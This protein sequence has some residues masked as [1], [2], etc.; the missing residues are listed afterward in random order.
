MAITTHWVQDF[1][2]FSDKVSP[3]ASPVLTNDL[4]N[5]NVSHGQVRPRAGLSN[6]HSDSTPAATTIIGLFDY[7]LVSGTNQIVRMLEAG[8]E[9]WNGSSWLDITP[10][11]TLTGSST[12]RPQACVIDD[13][14]IFT[15]EGADLPHKY[16][17]SG[18]AAIIA[19]GL[20][21]YGKVIQAYLGFLMLGDVS[22]SGA[23]T[24]ITDGQRIINY[25]DDWDTDWSACN[26]NEIVLWETPGSL[27]RMLVL[28]RDL[29]CYKTDG[30]VRVT[31][32][33]GQTVFKQEKVDFNIGFASPL[34][35]QAVNDELHIGLGNDG[36][37]YSITQTEVTPLTYD[38]LYKT[39]PNTQSLGKFKYAR[40]MDDS[41]NA[42]FYLFYDRTGLTGQLLDSYAAFN[43]RD[44]TVVKGR[45]GKSIISCSPHKPTSLVGFDLLVSTTT[46]VDEFN[47]GVTD[48]ST[49]ISSYWTTGPQ[50]LSEEGWLVGCR[51]IFDKPTGKSCHVEVS[52]SVGGSSS[53]QFP[54]TFRL[55]GGAPDDDFVEIN[56]QPPALF[57]NFFDIKIK[58]KSSSLDAGVELRRIG[59]ELESKKPV[60]MLPSRGSGALAL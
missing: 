14:L 25:S 26:G 59:L 40:G 28:G 27:L 36:V 6:Y 4:L 2:G 47:S 24:D 46:L 8:V 56:Y 53:F 37:I 12:T 39:I 49:A 60:R 17:G 15:N 52:V 45:L 22:T 18:D 42:T 11:T 19:G 51:L 38:S 23:F 33:G 31:W 3:G 50:N 44:K 1:K 5:V 34:A 48:D 9:Y 10:A 21:G 30:L 35:I 41:E 7:P 54:T 32:V 16:T 43:Y 29:M 55:V 13:T 58:F 20:S 57:G